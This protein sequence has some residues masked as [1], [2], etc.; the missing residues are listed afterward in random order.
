MYCV[1]YDTFIGL[2]DIKDF[3]IKPFTCYGSI[4]EN[5]YVDV[6]KA[7]HQAESYKNRLLQRL[8]EFNI[9]VRDVKFSDLNQNKYYYKIELEDHTQP[10][11]IYVHKFSEGDN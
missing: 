1:Y 3:S 2:H 7:N 9:N 6:E 11:F 5:I 4:S 8:K 10:L